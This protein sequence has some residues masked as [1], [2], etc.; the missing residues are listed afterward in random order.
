LG[1]E[2]FHWWRRMRLQLCCLVLRND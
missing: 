2:S 1:T